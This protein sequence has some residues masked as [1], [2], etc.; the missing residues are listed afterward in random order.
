MRGAWK[1]GQKELRPACSVLKCFRGCHTVLR[2]YR[3]RLDDLQWVSPVSLAWWSFDQ[4]LWNALPNCYDRIWK[5]STAPVNVIRE[6]GQMLSQQ[7]FVKW[8]DRIP[9]WQRQGLSTK[10]NKG[11]YNNRAFLRP[12]K[13]Q[14]ASIIFLWTWDVSHLLHTKFQILDTCGRV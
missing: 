9:Q 10:R 14:C 6:R 2:S 12:T 1:T 5:E 3:L 11:S 8:T 4:I 13:T 7:N